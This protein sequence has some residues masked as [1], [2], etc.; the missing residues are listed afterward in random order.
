MFLDNVACDGGEQT[1]LDCSSGSRIG[2]IS[3]GCACTTF[4]DCVEDLGVMCPG[5]LNTY[6]CIIFSSQLL[7]VTGCS[8]LLFM[9][10]YINIRNQISKSPILNFILVISQIRMSV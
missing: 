5:L 3:D 4:E 6:M 9:H 10:V 2:L 1:L 7:Q 8:I